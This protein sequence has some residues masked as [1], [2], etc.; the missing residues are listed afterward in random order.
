[1]I[2]IGPGRRLIPL[3]SPRA[4][5]L[6]RRL[7][8]Q[9]QGRNVK[10]PTQV[11]DLLGNAKLSQTAVVPADQDTHEPRSETTLIQAAHL[12][13][14]PGYPGPLPNSAIEWGTRAG[15]ESSTHLSFIVCRDGLFAPRELM[16]VYREVIVFI[17]C[18][19]EEGD[20]LEPERHGRL[21]WGRL[22]SSWIAV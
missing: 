16:R 17:R 6:P 13:I 18:E 3:R 9:G 12:L 2:Y 19:R 1:M 14:H 15:L 4:R 8:R 22:D 20:G 10:A 5:S 11:K 7:D 21:V